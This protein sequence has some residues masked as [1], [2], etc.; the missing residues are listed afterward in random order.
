[1]VNSTEPLNMIKIND[2]K[3]YAEVIYFK[4]KYYIDKELIE[5]KEKYILY[6]I[7]KV[8]EAEHKTLI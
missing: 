3:S 7:F 5:G 2:F 8:N 1:M 6:R 4:N